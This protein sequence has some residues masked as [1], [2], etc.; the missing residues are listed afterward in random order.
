MYT[1]RK[2]KEKEHG[3]HSLQ[4]Q[5]SHSASVELWPFRLPFDANS[6]F[7]GLLTQRSIRLSNFSRKRAPIRDR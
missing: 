5:I 1:A 2:K 6:I 4:R 3:N 7:F